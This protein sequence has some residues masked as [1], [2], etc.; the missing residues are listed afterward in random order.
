[1]NKTESSTIGGRIKTLRKK[2]GYNQK[3]LANLLG[4][5]LR[6]VQKYESGEIEVS[7]AMVNELAKILDTTST[8]LLGHQTGDFKFDCLSDVMECL[9]QLEKISGLHFSIGTKRPPHHD[10]WQCSITFDGK[11]KSADQNADICLFLEEWEN[12]RESFRDYM[13]SKET[14]EN[15]KDKTLAYYASQGVEIAEPD[16]LDETERLKRRNARFSGK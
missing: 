11:D 12:N 8:Y 2:R 16:E 13:I 10:G 4:K 15:W 1:M 5:S 3:D 7:I 6:T 14:Y 9:F